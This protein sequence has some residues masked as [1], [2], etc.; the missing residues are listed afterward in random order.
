LKLIHTATGKTR[1][2]VPSDIDLD[3]FFT[4]HRL[5]GADYTVER[6]L[7]EQ[8]EVLQRDLEFSVA[9]TSSLL[10]ST[11]D[12]AAIA[13]SA[14]ATLVKGLESGVTL[15]DL[16]RDMAPYAP[17][18]IAFADS[19]DAGDTVLPYTLKGTIDEV[20]P[21]LAARATAVSGVVANP[22]PRAKPARGQSGR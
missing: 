14:V 11:S 20:L 22:T 12:G 10:D 8:R 16:K 4:R 1:A 17:A 21:Q 19:V 9:D 2:V 15:A 3:A 7:Q 13:L 5:N 18:L 6:T